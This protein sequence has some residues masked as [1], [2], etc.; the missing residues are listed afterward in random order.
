MSHLARE[1]YRQLVW[2][3]KQAQ[4]LKLAVDDLTNAGNALMSDT[5]GWDEEQAAVISKALLDW[6]DNCG[7]SIGYATAEL[8]EF[9][10]D[11]LTA[12]RQR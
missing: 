2:I 9:R 6:G 1:L 3:D 10:R 12:L 4:D 5:E 8:N 7:R 11:L